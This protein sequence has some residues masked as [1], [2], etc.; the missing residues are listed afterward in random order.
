MTIMEWNDTLAVDGGV[1]DDTHKEFVELLNKLGEVEGDAVLPAIDEFI[2]HTEEHFL[3]EQRWMQ[4]IPFP[5]IHCHVNEHNGVL[6]ICREVR[7]RV[8]NGETRYSKVLA[9]AIGE[10]FKTHASSMDTVLAMVMKEQGYAATR[11]AG[12]VA[13]KQPVLEAAG[14]CG[15]SGGG[16]GAG[17]CGS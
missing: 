5:P 9:Q 17:G 6:D 11:G 2:A 4:E 15:C 12:D 3:Q 7:T 13:V 16:A 1:M 10:W 8:A 14:G